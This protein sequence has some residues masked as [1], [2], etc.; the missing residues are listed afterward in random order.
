MFEG[1]SSHTSIFSG[2][3][4]LSPASV[5]M[6]D[7]ARVQSWLMLGPAQQ[8]QLYQ[9]TSCPFCQGGST[10]DGQ[11]SLVL[12]QASCMDEHSQ[13]NHSKPQHPSPSACFLQLDSRLQPPLNWSISTSAGSV[14]PLWFFLSSQGGW[15]S[16]E[17]Q[18]H[19]LSRDVKFL[20][21]TPNTM[22]MNA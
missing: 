1:A 10:F 18:R 20:F 13:L 8:L 5:T 2:I 3:S 9:A 11:K 14:F 19:G 4:P 15:A 16:S 7:H 6:S 21:L 12:M 22:Q 17:I